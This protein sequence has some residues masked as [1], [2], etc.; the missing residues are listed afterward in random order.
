MVNKLAKA[1]RTKATRATRQRK[2]P[3]RI[4]EEERILREAT[5]FLIHKVG[6]LLVA[7]GLREERR[8][9]ARRWIVT[10]TLRY[11]TDYEA[12]WGD[13]LYDGETFS[14]LT[15]PEVLREREQAI[16]HDPLRRQKWHDYRN[17]SLP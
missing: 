10:V 14:V 5:I 11:P 8:R 7:T 15:P 2:Q 12:Y 6:G 3:Q 16:E 4:E 13:L 1:V 9:G 17:S